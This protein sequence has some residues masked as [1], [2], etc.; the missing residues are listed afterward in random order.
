MSEAKSHKIRNL[1]AAGVL[2]TTFG[3]RSANSANQIQHSGQS[4][5]TATPNSENQT[6]IDGVTVFFE[7]DGLPISYKV[8]DEVTIMSPDKIRDIKYLIKRAKDKKEPQFLMNIPGQDL[9][10]GNSWQSNPDRPYIDKMPS[11]VLTNEE[12]KKY[13]VSQIIQGAETKLLIRK[14]AFE[15]GAILYDLLRAQS[16]K[17]SIKLR[18]VLVDGPV[19]AQDYMQDPRYDDVREFAFSRRE[20]PDQYRDRHV[21]VLGANLQI[22]KT[23]LHKAQLT[24][25]SNKQ[26]EAIYNI[27]N[28]ETE[29]DDYQNASFEELMQKINSDQN[30]SAGLYIEPKGVNGNGEQVATIFIAAGVSQPVQERLKLFADPDGKI[31]IAESLGITSEFYDYRADESKGFPRQSDFRFNP[32]ATAKNNSYPYGAQDNE[33]GEDLHHEIEHLRKITLLPQ[34]DGIT[35]DY[36]EYDTDIEAMTQVEKEYDTWKKNGYN[37]NQNPYPFVLKGGNDYFQVTKNKS[38]IQPYHEET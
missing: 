11:D 31:Y 33:A 38:V 26:T 5:E 7:K 6:E 35:P 37:P 8:Y 2:A 1:F 3:L 18:I 19:V 16:L 36:S 22:A 12:L 13:G 20:G 24:H 21:N 14:E 32:N 30:H 17:P 4:Q 34:L 27:Y 25:D 9:P 10:I 28:L 29:I 23:N 15:K